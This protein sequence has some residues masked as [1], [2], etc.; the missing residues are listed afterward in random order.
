MKERTNI[1]FIYSST[2]YF[3]PSHFSLEM[4]EVGECLCKQMDREKQM[5]LGMLI[6]QSDT[7]LRVFC[8]PLRLLTAQRV[9]LDAGHTV[10]K[11]RKMPRIKMPKHLQKKF[12]FS[13]SGVENVVEVRHFPTLPEMSF[14]TV[15]R[16]S[17]TPRWPSSGGSSI[18]APLPTS[19][20]K[21]APLP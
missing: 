5:I 16:A 20:P 19:P 12:L 13:V 17:K 3:L 9:T 6:L 15:S 21:N 7:K 1:Y 4:E 18:A 2:F 10:L 8:C 11:D 14:S